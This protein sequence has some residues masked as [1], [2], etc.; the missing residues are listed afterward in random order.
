M[1]LAA[2]RW[3]WEQNIAAGSKY[4]LLAL[5]DYADVQGVCFPSQKIL[6][7]KCG[8]SRSTINAHLRALQNSSL[9]MIQR[10]SNSSGYRCASLYRLRLNQTP[11]LGQREIQSLDSGHPKSETRTWSCQE[12]RQHVTNQLT[13][14]NKLLCPESGHRNNSVTKTEKP[15]LKDAL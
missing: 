2:I 7:K 15:A 8:L 14:H 6:A 5:A 1:S 11:N 12:S 13:N 9:I 3:A 10:R 4:V